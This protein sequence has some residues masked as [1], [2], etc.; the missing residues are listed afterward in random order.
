MHEW[1]S[2]RVCTTKTNLLTSK[3][4]NIRHLGILII[5]LKPFSSNRGFE[6]SNALLWMEMQ[7]VTV[8][9]IISSAAKITP[10]SYSN[11]L[12]LA[13][14]CTTRRLSSESS[15]AP[16]PLSTE[17]EG[18][19]TMKNASMAGKNLV[20]SPEK[21]NQSSV[22]SRA[23]ILSAKM[24]C[25]H[26]PAMLFWSLG[27]WPLGIS[28]AWTCSSEPS[29]SFS[30]ESRLATPKKWDG[31]VSERWLLFQ[32]PKKTSYQ[33]SNTDT[34][35]RQLSNCFHND[36]N[37]RLC[38]KETNSVE[39]PSLFTSSSWTHSEVSIWSTR[40]SFVSELLVES[41]TALEFVPA[42]ISLSTTSDPSTSFCC[43]F[44]LRFSA[45]EL[46]RIPTA[47]KSKIA[48]LPRASDS[49]SRDEIG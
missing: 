49:Y 12:L 45:A 40:S 46:K 7:N 32:W 22:K 5:A 10:M 43:V 21:E 19:F 39:F 33:P 16:G 18:V 38:N 13:A 6:R 30:S 41:E 34:V 15:E 27:R 14:N 29:I 48:I 47:L 23:S 37:L 8:R 28:P 9:A 25:K 44:C 31:R 1:E 3:S 35:L 4:R 2:I 24:T 26:K 36:S 17:W 11:I 42:T 20:I